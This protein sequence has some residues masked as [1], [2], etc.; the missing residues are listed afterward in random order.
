MV[1]PANVLSLI[2]QR[3]KSW[4]IRLG[5]WNEGQKKVSRWIDI[6]CGFLQGDNYLPV[7]FCL[8]EIPVIKLLQ[9]LPNGLNRKKRS[10]TDV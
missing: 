4:K 10:D 8:S 3:V 1:L 2:T 5:I 6:T 7:G 9:R